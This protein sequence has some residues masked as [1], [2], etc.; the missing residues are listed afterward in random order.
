MKYQKSKII[1]LNGPSSSGKTTLGRNIQ[2][3]IS[4]PFLYLSSD[5]LVESKVLPNLSEFENREE[6]K[7]KNIRPYFFDGFH[8][9][10]A[11]FAST[12][13]NMI[14]EHVLE[15]REWYEK[16]IELLKP[17]D[18]FYVGVFCPIQEMEKREQKRG[19]RFIG[20]GLS[21]L[22]EGVHNWGP[23]DLTIDT[24]QYSA[25]DAAN[26]VIQAFQNRP[27]ITSFKK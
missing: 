25:L 27:K 12:G 8:S 9:T 18:V 14:V 13:N 21:H 6:W 15:K 5:Q 22:K 23:Y 4:E 16:C 7:W 24:F 11:A 10:I 1:F 19:D 3:Q 20:E 17:F 2:N 26:K